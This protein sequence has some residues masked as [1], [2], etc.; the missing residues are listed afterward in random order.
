[1]TALGSERTGL[2]A[3]LWIGSADAALEVEAEPDQDHHI[4]CVQFLPFA[5]E[6]R[7]D[8]RPRYDG[9]FGAGDV[10]IVPAGSRPTAVMRGPFSCLHLYLPHALVRD[11]AAEGE[12]ARVDGDVEVIDPRRSRDPPIERVAMEVLR[13]MREGDVLSRLRLDALGL[14]LAVQVLRRH[15][16][17]AG[18]ATDRRS[19]RRGGLAPWQVRR[20]VE[21]IAAG[22]MRDVSLT[23]LAPEAG[24]SP[25]HFARAFK[26]S[27]GVP[28]H[29][30]QVRLRIERAQALLLR[31]DLPVTEIALEVG[32]DSS[33]ALARAFRRQVGC[34]PSAY[35]RERRV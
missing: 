25:F 3:A 12:H 13:E 9:P 29:A 4:V 35:R 27:V 2:S 6:F 16:S 21:M 18:P 8:S 24:L 20:C 23:L 17:A 15:S 19:M 34:S 7:L 31:S 11:A 5:A 14:D 10:S 32:Y 1:M 22:S 30:Y 28:P 26:T 33:Q